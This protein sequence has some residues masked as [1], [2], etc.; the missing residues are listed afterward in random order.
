MGRQIDHKQQSIGLSALPVAPQLV[1]GA[2][3]ASNV[4][5]NQ[6]TQPGGVL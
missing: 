4:Y 6:R 5:R 3:L 2:L 1:R